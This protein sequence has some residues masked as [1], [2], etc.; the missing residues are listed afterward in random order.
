[1]V[2]GPQQRKN[3][4]A[5]GRHAGSKAYGLQALLHGRDFRLQRID[6]RV[7]LPTISVAG[8]VTLKY[9]SEVSGVGISERNRI[10]NWLVN[11]SVLSTRRTVVMNNFGSETF[12]GSGGD[13]GG[14]EL[15]HTSA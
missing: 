12:H 2:T 14:R 6:R 15:Y 4:G 13:S 3:R 8:N 9:I 10:V 5:D 1:M 11:R 7:Y